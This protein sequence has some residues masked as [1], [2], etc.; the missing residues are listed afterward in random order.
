VF[1]RPRRTEDWHDEIWKALR[2]TYAFVGLVS[3]DFNASAFCQQEIGAALSLG[4]PSVL[5]FAGS[6]HVPGFAAR[7]QAVK[8]SRL[9]ETLQLP[10]FRQL[11]LEAWIRGTKTADSFA[12]ANAIYTHFRDEWKTMAEA[13][14]LRWLLAGA[15][16][17]Q[18]WDEGYRV[19]PFFKQV[20][21]DLK[22]W[23]TDQWLFENDKDGVLHDFERNPVG[24]KK[25]KKKKK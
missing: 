24:L 7:F 25:K 10:P 12:T 18:V 15:S 3:D 4:K 8:R 22:P 20:K 9:L 19:G 11:R 14:Q 13:E 21:D 2:N 5:V 16:N 6:R 17:R 23:L 1:P